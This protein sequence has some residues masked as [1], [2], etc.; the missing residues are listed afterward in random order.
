MKGKEYI[1]KRYEG[2]DPKV[3]MTIDDDQFIQ[4]CHLAKG[5]PTRTLSFHGFRFENAATTLPFPL[6]LWLILKRTLGLITQEEI[7]MLRVKKLVEK[8]DG[9][10][11]KQ[12]DSMVRLIRGVDKLIKTLNGRAK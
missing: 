3:L 11:T 8:I 12:R 9:D 5:E 4:I 10:G 6:D 1:L 7:V 2:G